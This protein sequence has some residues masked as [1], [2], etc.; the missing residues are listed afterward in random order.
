MD[1]Y[2]Q[3]AIDILTSENDWKAICTAMAKMYPKEF[4]EACHKKPWQIEA[5][6]IN[7]TEGKIAAI[8]YIRTQTGMDLKETKKT[9]E[10]LSANS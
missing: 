4:C 2:Y 3:Q 9:I 7:N 6:R 1:A 10:D 5:L 8:K